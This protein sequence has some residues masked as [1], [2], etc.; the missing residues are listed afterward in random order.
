M[1]GCSGSR[2]ALFRDEPSPVLLPRAMSCDHPG[3]AHPSFLPVMYLIW[4]IPTHAVSCRRLRQKQPARNVARLRCAERTGEGSIVASRLEDVRGGCD[5]G[6]TKRFGEMFSH[7]YGA[8]GVMRPVSDGVL[9][10][11][12]YCC[13]RCRPMRTPVRRV[14]G[15]FSA[16]LRAPAGAYLGER[17]GFTSIKGPSLVHQM[18]TLTI[19]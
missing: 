14:S 9:E 11:H 12:S 4:W 10:L 19:R 5:G 15:L 8:Y 16:S 17:M 6:L 18:H 3:T 1:T 13:R 7:A 2:N